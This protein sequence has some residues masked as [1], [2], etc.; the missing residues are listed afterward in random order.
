MY[1]E[2]PLFSLLNVYIVQFSKAQFYT[3]VEASVSRHRREAEK[4]SATGADRLRESVNTE[5]V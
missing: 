5:F 3:T 4:V 1:Q 2:S